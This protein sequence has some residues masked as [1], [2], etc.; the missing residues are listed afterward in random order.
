MVDKCENRL[1]ECL[2]RQGA[3][4]YSKKMQSGDFVWVAVP[5]AE[6]SPQVSLHPIPYSIYVYICIYIYIDR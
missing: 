1:T 4:F 5:R 6:A 2:E 3:S